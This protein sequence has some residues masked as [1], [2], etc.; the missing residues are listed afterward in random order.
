M[1]MTFTMV[2]SDQELRLDINEWKSRSGY[3]KT[4]LESPLLKENKIQFTEC[5]S[6]QFL[7][8]VR[9][10]LDPKNF[11]SDFQLASYL[12]APSLIQQVVQPILK[13]EAIEY[14]PY[15]GAPT[16]DL[17]LSTIALPPLCTLQSLVGLPLRSLNLSGQNRLGSKAWANIGKITSLQELN[18]SKTKISTTSGFAGLINLEVL[19]LSGCEQLGEGSLDGLSNLSKLRVLNI[20]NCSMI[21][22]SDIQ[23]IQSLALQVFEMRKVVSMVPSVLDTIAKMTTLTKLDVSEN[24]Q[25]QNDIADLCKKLKGV[26]IIK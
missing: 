1:S 14:E 13:N 22:K 23:Q 25:F 4:A 26:D 9:G 7:A 24:V 6:E 17:D 12:D 16:I 8:L 5:S 20:N 18:V 15:E 3:I 11:V 19:I 2:F 21:K 10:A